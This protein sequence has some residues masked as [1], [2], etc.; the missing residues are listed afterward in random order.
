MRVRNRGLVSDVRVPLSVVVVRCAGEEIRVN[1]R[2]RTHTHHV[3]VIH[4][5]RD[6]VDLESL[7]EQVSGGGS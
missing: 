1:L 6:L 3:N 2:H 4:R 7:E 5:R